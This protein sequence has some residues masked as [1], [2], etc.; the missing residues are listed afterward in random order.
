MSKT[1]KLYFKDL[2]PL[3]F[4]AY[5][6][7]LFWVCLEINRTKKEGV[8]N[9]LADIFASLSI[10]S[11][12][13][14]FFLSAFLITSLALREY[15]YKKSF[16]LR[17]FYLRKLLRVLPI[18]VLALFFAL[19]MH[20]YILSV[21]KLTPIQDAE[22]GAYFLGLPNYFAT[23][24]PDRLT[25]TLVI[26][27]VYMILQFYVVWGL[28][29]KYLNPYIVWVSVI[30]VGIGIVARIL[31][32]AN[33][34]PFYF[35]T[36]SYGVP[37]GI[38]GILAYLVRNNKAL[39]NRIK[40]LSK[41]QIVLGYGV[42]TFGLIS[43]YVLFKTTYFA[44]FIP[45]FTGLFFAFVV[46]EQT[47]NKFSILKLR[48]L[49]ILNRFGKISYGLIV[50]TPIIAVV[51]SIVFESIDK[52]IDSNVFKMLFILIT[53]VVAIVIANVLYNTYEKLFRYIRRDYKRI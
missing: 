2:N 4:I 1:R 21:L 32:I 10:N 23:V 20:S 52:A 48:K 31:L 40:K 13:F 50:L 14:F 34:Q 27:S 33:Q 12:D 30:F 25:Y 17:K 39:I 6:P 51:L 7:I 42:G 45:L 43:F 24:Q 41:A 38:G 36:L 47:F 46:L 49:K 28:I 22:L 44:A 35:D 3:R 26:F 15:K 29:L 53:F 37:I 18:L 19:F 8:V 11:L 9:L 16:S 5:L